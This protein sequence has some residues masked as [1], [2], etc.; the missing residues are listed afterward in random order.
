ME[1]DRDPFEELPEGL[2]E[3]MLD[4]SKAVSKGLLHTFEEIKDKREELR[5][6]LEDNGSL[7]SYSEI[8]TARV[9]PTT[10][11]V[12]G[13]YTM[14]RMLATDLACVAA[15]A[16]EGLT[17]P[18]PEKRNWP[19]PRYFSH[20]EAVAHNDDTSQVLRGISAQLE[21]HLAANAPHDVVLLDG[22]IKTPLIF[23]NNATVKL[24][25]IPAT[26]R[27]VLLMGKNAT[28]EDMVKFPGFSDAIADF[29]EILKCNRS[30]KVY[31]AVPKYTT[32]NELCIKIGLDGYEDRS[33]LNFIMKGGEY[34]GPLDI[35]STETLHLNIDAVNKYTTINEDVRET[36]RRITNELIPN[37]MVLYFRPST[38]GPVIRVE[39]AR[40]VAENTYRLR[41]LF[42]SLRIQSASTSIMEPYPLYLADRMVKHL[43]TALPAIRKSAVQEISQN[44]PSNI[45]EIYM[46]M[47]A[48]RTEGGYR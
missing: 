23:L 38:F 21:L 29:E 18:G 3:E 20:I 37:M 12:D 34:I 27:D 7:K 17:P 2:V 24:Q 5:K 47:H 48:Y 14:D 46:A 28:N 1:S 22:S 33:V 44:W 15:V 11:G 40:Q 43:S 41:T 4:S 36:V 16:V 10:C 8:D 32:Q 30:D 19:K 35:D 25:S 9:Y 45:S 6:K 39:V 26:L 31:A 42:E 13:S